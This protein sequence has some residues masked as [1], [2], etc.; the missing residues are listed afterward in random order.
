MWWESVIDHLVQAHSNDAVAAV[1]ALICD[2]LANLNSA[3]FAGFMA[4]RMF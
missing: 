3:L 4:S 1:R 2:L